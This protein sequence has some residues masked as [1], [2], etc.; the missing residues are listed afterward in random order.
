MHEPDF[1]SLR[2]RLL[3]GGVAPK[4]VRRTIAELRDHHADLF[5]EAFAVWSVSGA[6]RLFCSFGLPVFVAG[7]AVSSPVNDGW[8]C[9]GR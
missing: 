3:R 1:H 4:H 9:G 6:I 8:H 7:P 2:E 5:A